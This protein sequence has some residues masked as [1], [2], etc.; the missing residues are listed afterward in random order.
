MPSD[1]LTS[2][3]RRCVALPLAALLPSI[4]GVC[5]SLSSVAKTTVTP[6][7]EKDWTQWTTEDCRL[8]RVHSPWAQFSFP[9]GIDAT[10]FSTLVQIRS[11]LPVREALLKEL[12]LENHYDEMKAD[13]KQVFDQAHLHDLSPIDQVRVYISNE[14]HKTLVGAAELRPAKQIALRLSHGEFIMPLETNPVKYTPTEAGNVLV[15]YE[16]V[17]PRTADGKPLYS[18]SDTFLIVELGAPLFLDKKTHQVIPQPFQDSGQ[19][20]TFKISDLM[21]KGNLEY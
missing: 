20:Y 1:K 13:K 21:Y 15:Q 9:T 3:A 7:I 11:A 16:Y 19:R 5:F 2:I 12:E 17:F 4:L 6:W 8:V 14:A 18:P 10:A